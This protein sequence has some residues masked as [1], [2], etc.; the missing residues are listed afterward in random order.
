MSSEGRAS[1][2]WTAPA[3]RSARVEVIYYKDDVHG[4]EHEAAGMTLTV[5]VTGAD[6]PAPGGSPMTV[7]FPMP[8]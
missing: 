1:T 3:S 4:A 5:H 2:S 6:P 8:M 7:V